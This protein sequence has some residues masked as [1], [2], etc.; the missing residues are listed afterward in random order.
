MCFCVVSLIF[1]V[2]GIHW[3]SWIC[4]IIV[5]I[6]LETFQ[7]LFPPIYFF[8]LLPAL[9]CFF[10]F[11]SSYTCDSPLKVVLQLTDDTF[12]FFTVFTHCFTIL[13]LYIRVHQSF[14]LKYFLCFQS[15]QACFMSDIVL[16]ISRSSIYFLYHS[17]L[18]I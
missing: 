18:S 1:S 4:G 10:F 3:A 6:K 8:L 12:T 11:N 17:C 7:P 16:F 5:F 15:K 13:L 14:L 2:L 9:R